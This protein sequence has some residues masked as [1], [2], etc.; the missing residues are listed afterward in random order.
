MTNINDNTTNITMPWY[1][2]KSLFS[3]SSEFGGD[4]SVNQVSLTLSSGY[5]LVFMDATDLF[6]RFV[7]DDFVGYFVG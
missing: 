4:C 6:E 5:L 3:V 7:V 1:M 2:L